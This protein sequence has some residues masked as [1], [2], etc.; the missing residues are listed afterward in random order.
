MQSVPIT[1]DVVSSNLDQRQVY[2]IMWKILSVTCDRSVVFSE[3][4]NGSYSNQKFLFK[5]KFLQHQI[6]CLFKVCSHKSMG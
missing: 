1:T 4:S 3:T 5:L 2:N 6:F